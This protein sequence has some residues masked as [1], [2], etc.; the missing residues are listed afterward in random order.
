MNTR[1]FSHSSFSGTQHTTDSYIRAHADRH[2]LPNLAQR[3]ADH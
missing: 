3:V 1:P 2:L